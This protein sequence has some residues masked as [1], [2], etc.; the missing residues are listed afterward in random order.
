MFAVAACLAAADGHHSWHMLHR[1]ERVSRA[2][3]ICR[4]KYLYRVF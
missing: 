4:R 3:S 1:I 2:L